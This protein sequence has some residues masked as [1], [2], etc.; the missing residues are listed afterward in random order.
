VADL[1]EGTEEVQQT[2]DLSALRLEVEALRAKRDEAL[3]EAKRAKERARAF[4]GV[5]PNE[6]RTLKQKLAEMEQAT[7]GEQAGLN[8]EAIAKLRADIRQQLESEYSPFKQ[9]A[10]TLSKEV[11][12]LKLD[13][14]V[15]SIMAKSGVR[16]DRVD[17]L[18][19]L[20]AGQF[21]LTDDG[22]PVVRENEAIEIDK[23]IAGELVKAYPEWFE[24][25]GSSGGGAPRTQA[26]GGA[27][28][29]RVVSINDN[30]AFIA[31]LDGIAKGTVKVQ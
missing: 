9:Q 6:Y 19:R 16:A 20:T 29:S 17:D 11:R 27:R 22:Q 28:V 8:G 21:D 15:K 1:E 5:D 2:D 31:N 12:E 25:T 23:Y 13:T 14:R 30:D 3:T 26:A 10:D 24:G 18:F 4:D 7:K